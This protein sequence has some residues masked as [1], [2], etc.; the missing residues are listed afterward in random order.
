[1]KIKKLTSLIA[2]SVCAF[3]FM[4]TPLIGCTPASPATETSYEIVEASIYDWDSFESP[5]DEMD[6]TYDEPNPADVKM[7]IA[8]LSDIHLQVRDDHATRNFKRAVD[9]CVEMADGNLD[10]VAIVGDVNDTLWWS[11]VNYSEEGGI[12]NRT[13]NSDSNRLIEIADLRK[14]FDQII[15]EGTSLMYTIGNH[16]MCT[17]SGRFGVPYSS[18]QKIVEELRKQQEGYLDRDYFEYLQDGEEGEYEDTLAESVLLEEGMRYYRQNGVNFIVL[19]ANKFYSVTSY[20]DGKINWLTGVLDYIRE[21]HAGEPVFIITHQP[22]N[23]S[24]IG[25]MSPNHS[26]DLEP[27]LKEYPEVILFTGHIHQSNYHENAIS[28]D[29]GF[30]VVET[31]STKYTDNSLYSEGKNYG[32]FN[33]SASSSSSQG[34][35]VRVMKDN[36]V[37]ISRIDFTYQKKSGKDWIVKPLGANG[38]NAIYTDEYRAKHNTIPYFKNAKVAIE[39]HDNNNPTKTYTGEYLTV[40]FSPAVDKE[41]IVRSYIIKAFNANGHVIKEILMD[42]GYS[43]GK[44]IKMFNASFD[45]PHNIHKIEIYAED[46]YFARSLPIVIDKEDFGEAFPVYDLGETYVGTSTKTGSVT[47]NGITYRSSEAFVETD[48]VLNNFNTALANG[49]SYFDAFASKYNFSFKISD[50]K[51]GYS[52]TTHGDASADYRL[53]VNLATFEQDGLIYSFNGMFD[54]GTYNSTTR[55]RTNTNVFTYYVTVSGPSVNTYSRSYALSAYGIDNV[56]LPSNTKEILK[57]VEGGVVKVER[58]GSEFTIKLNDSTIST[59]DLKGDYYV[60]SNVV[61]FNQKTKATF[62]IHIK[63]AEANF[64]NLTF[65]AQ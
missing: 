35:F 50:M 8:M 10:A 37:R 46:A 43:A 22:V 49:N 27:V 32:I 44:S 36:T 61:S 1:M 60:G 21:N 39:Y 62:G 18:D 6:L 40:K 4:V 41:T 38:K 45:Y 17:I 12:E 55:L 23:N 19:N 26:L 7:N 20:S 9:T 33:G 34:L 3:S 57:S 29:L 54:F 2:S 15:P 56:N 59:V 42:S 24:V 30:T 63:G 48:G 58:N 11:T 47:A 31:S 14:K 5:F 53:G 64:T 25:S 65:D 51:L 13:T 16:D 52:A 28:Q